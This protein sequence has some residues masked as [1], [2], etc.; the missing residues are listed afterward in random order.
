MGLLPLFH[1][2]HA[3]CAHTGN[4][5]DVKIKKMAGRMAEVRAHRLAGNLSLILCFLCNIKTHIEG[6][7][8]VLCQFKVWRP[9]EDRDD[10]GAT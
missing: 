4:S 7:D 2:P 1:L 8:F 9:E 10:K 6:L 5:A 3:H